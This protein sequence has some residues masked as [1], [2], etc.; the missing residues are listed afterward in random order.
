MSGIPEDSSSQGQSRL[1]KNSVQYRKAQTTKNSYKTGKPYDAGHPDA[2]STGDEAGKGESIG[3]IGG[4]TDIKM[5]GT[6]VVKNK[7]NNNNEYNA[8]NA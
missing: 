3:G 6:M 4:K 7:Y 5:R 2:L 8:G 1:E